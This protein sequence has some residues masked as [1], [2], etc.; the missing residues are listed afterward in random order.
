M[1]DDTIKRY[2]ELPYVLQ[3]LTDKSIFLCNPEAWD[4]K[5]DSHYVKIYKEKK[6]LKTVLAVC[7]TSAEQTYHHWRIFTHG[8]SG[9][10]IH[11]NKK[12]FHSWLSQQKDIAGREIIYKTLP[13][14]QKN[15]PKLDELPFLKRSAYKHESEL[16]LLFEHKT[17]IFPL[18]KVSFPIAIIERILI[19]PWLPF[20]TVKVLK[21]IINQIPGCDNIVVER[22]TIINNEDWKKLANSV[23]T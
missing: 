22:A 7:L 14:L 9:A 23:N 1:A 17:E 10:C 11:F 5:N 18:K 15:P 12:K 2:T 21:A 4:D 13:T 20:E 16:R 8:S 3:S 19:N 6:E